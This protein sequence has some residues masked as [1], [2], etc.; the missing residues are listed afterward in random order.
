MSG[1]VEGWRGQTEDGRRSGKKPHLSLRFI[2]FLE[3]MQRLIWREGMSMP[4]SRGRF[5][6][7]ARACVRHTPKHSCP[8]F[9]RVLRKIPPPQVSI[10]PSSIA[11]H[12]RSQ[13]PT[14]AGPHR[15]KMLRL[16]EVGASEAVQTIYRPVCA[17]TVE[18]NHDFSKLLASKPVSKILKF[19]QDTLC[20]EARNQ[21]R[22][23]RL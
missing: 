19:W 3:R 16:V 4:G 14:N 12:R 7:T 23:H 20:L 6:K 21:N 17:L 10:F 22:T 1:S 11:P 5:S 15:E 8:L 18:F 9:H 13:R 2:Y